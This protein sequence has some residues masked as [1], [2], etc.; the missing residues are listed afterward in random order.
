MSKTSIP[1][2]EETMRSVEFAAKI[3]GMTPGEVVARLVAQASI[4]APPEPLRGDSSHTELLDVYSDYDGIRTHARFDPT[5][6]R[7]EITA[8]PLVGR[9]FKT[10]SAAARA[11]VAQL[12]PGIDPNRNGWTFWRLDNGSGTKLQT[13]KPRQ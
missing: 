3:A 1:L 2:D 6:K 11:V 10:P 8:G 7:I 5:T 13:M 9:R 4:P 12:K